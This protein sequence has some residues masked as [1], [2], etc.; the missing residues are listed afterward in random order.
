MLT[1]NTIIDKIEIL[2]ESGVMQI[3]EATIISE[4]GVELSRTYHRHCVAPG[5]KTDAEPQLVQDVASKVHT[6][7][8]ITEYLAKIAANEAAIIKK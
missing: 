5:D 6:E 1:K 3:R 7:A 8:K 2:P 4:D